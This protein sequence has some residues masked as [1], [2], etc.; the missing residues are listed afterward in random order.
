MSG[1]CWSTA[2]MMLVSMFDIPASKIRIRPD[3]RHCPA[4]L[5]IPSSGKM[6]YVVHWR[7]QK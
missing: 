2:V 4:M 5:P 6:G 7:V 3:A 1:D